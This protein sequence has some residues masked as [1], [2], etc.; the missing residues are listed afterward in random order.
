MDRD[1]KVKI[2]ATA[3]PIILY[4][5]T[6]TSH[7]LYNQKIIAVTQVQVWQFLMTLTLFGIYP[8]FMVAAKRGHGP[9]DYW[10]YRGTMKV[11]LL[12]SLL[13]YLF[14]RITESLWMYYTS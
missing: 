6:L 8:V 11:S 2:V 1:R 12:C 10:T 9:K 14:A 5:S 13:S 3:I 7:W 4:L